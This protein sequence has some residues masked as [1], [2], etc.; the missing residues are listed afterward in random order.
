[1]LP[2]ASKPQKFTNCCFTI[3]IKGTEKKGSNWG[4]RKLDMNRAPNT[5][6]QPPPSSWQSPSQHGGLP[7][8]HPS[9]CNL[10]EAW[11]GLGADT[12]R[13]SFTSRSKY[14]E[15]LWV[16]GIIT[17]IKKWDGTSIQRIRYNHMNLAC[18]TTGEEPTWGWR[19]K[20]KAPMEEGELSRG[21]RSI[22]VTRMGKLTGLKTRKESCL[23]KT[24]RQ[25]KPS[26]HLSNAMEDKG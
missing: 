3:S 21:Q 14:W 24:W 16:R 11:C 18:A 10:R 2:C 4:A 15:I 19:A 6:T 9:R 22:G 17:E 8:T 25:E 5:I 20:G 12:W 23:H 26:L 7:G 1:M 13:M